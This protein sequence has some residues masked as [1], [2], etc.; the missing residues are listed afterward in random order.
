MTRQKVVIIGAGVVGA[1]VGL[2]MARA[3]HAVTI[4]ERSPGAGLGSTSA[5]SGVIRF[6]YS[7]V[8]GVAMAYEGLEY[9]R[10]WATHLGLPEGAMLTQLREVG[11]VLIDDGT[12]VIDGTIEPMRT[13]GVP[14]ELLDA[15]A[16]AQR[17]PGIDTSSF[18]PAARSDDD[19]FFAEPTRTINQAVWSAEGGY[20]SDPQLAAQNLA[21]AAALA[22]ATLAYSTEIAGIV[23]AEGKVTGVDLVGG[24]H[25]GC[26]V[27]VNVAGPHSSTINTMAGLDGT[28]AISTRALR[29]QVDYASASADFGGDVRDFPAFGDLDVGIYVRPEGDGMLIGGV[30]AECDPMVWLDDP[31]D[32]DLALDGDE[33]ETKTLRLARRLPDFGVPHQR[34]GVVGVYDVSDDWTPIIDRTDLDGFY[35][36][37]GTSGNQFKNAPIIGRCM[38]ELVDAVEGGHDHDADPVVV[39]GPH[40]GLAIDLGTFARNRDGTASTGTV[41]G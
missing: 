9:W 2:E 16:L 21:D 15:N 41:M 1:A 28:M 12:G 34:R 11:F 13:V 29:Q 19:A 39:H 36:A 6:N 27:V 4:V 18:F 40:T 14:F 20:V 8:A 37:I 10:H 30:E 17:L 7:T 23:R 35:V 3:G 22:G 5:S 32:V 33:W 24:G 26:S 38:A 31:D 25:I